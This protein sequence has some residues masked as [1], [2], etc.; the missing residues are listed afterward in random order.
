MEDYKI[1]KRF[2]KYVEI[3]DNGCW[4]WKGCK[5]S[6]GYGRFWNG[7]KVVLAHRYALLG[8]DEKF[9]GR[10]VCHK[11]D[12]PACCNPDHL[13]T[14]TR[15]DNINDMIERNLDFGVPA[16]VFTNKVST[17]KAWSWCFSESGLNNLKE[18]FTHASVLLSEAR[19]AKIPCPVVPN[20]RS[21]L[22]SVGSR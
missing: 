11:C 13:Y 6:K 18:Y 9:E 7:E 8:L 20:L 17:T 1:S 2:W 16:I 14:G 15:L 22:S 19:F 10:M 21:I 12:H 3:S 5:S 4:Y